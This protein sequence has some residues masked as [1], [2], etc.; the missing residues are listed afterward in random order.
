MTTYLPDVQNLQVSAANVVVYPPGATLGLRHTVDHEFVWML[1]G[2]SVAYF[3]EKPVSAPPGTVLFRPKGITDRYEWAQDSRTVHAYFHFMCDLPKGDWL[4]PA[5][6]PA[7]RMLVADDIVSPLFRYVL[8][9]HL[10]DEPIRSS[11]LIPAFNLILKSYVSGHISQQAHAA[12]ELP[13]PVE[14]AMAEIRKRT[15][16]EPGRPLTLRDLARV[17]HVTPEHLCR[18]FRKTVRFGPLECARLARLQSAAML[19]GR[20]AMTVKE[21]ADATGFSTPYHFSRVFSQVYSL[22]PREY[23]RMTVSGKPVRSNPIIGFLHLERGQ[24]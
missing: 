8:N 1:E 7:S 9:I 24:S 11:L 23:R 21:V 17:A 16:Y 5:E 18:L 13:I 3:N 19:L 14:K 2:A 20:S 6:W 22:S 12:T 10:M 15:M 4:V